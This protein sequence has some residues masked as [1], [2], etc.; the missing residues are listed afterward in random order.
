[1]QQRAG[2]I[3]MIHVIFV[4][5]K[6]SVPQKGTNWPQIDIFCFSGGDTNKS[7]A[8]S[9]FQVKRLKIAPVMT[10]RTFWDPKLPHS[11]KPILGQNWEFRTLP[12]FRYHNQRE[13]C[14]ISNETKSRFH[15]YDTT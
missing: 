4:P 7:C 14:Q 15:S 6:G 11:H 1:M 10:D 9:K 5:G 8:Q 2:S 3:V 13:T 12:P